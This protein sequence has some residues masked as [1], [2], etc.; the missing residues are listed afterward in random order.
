MRLFKYNFGEEELL[1]LYII[2][3]S[4]E[5]KV[6]R[7]V[8]SEMHESIIRVEREAAASTTAYI[9]Q[10]IRCIQHSIF[11]WGFHLKEDAQ[12]KKKKKRILEDDSIYY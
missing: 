11:I 12:I 10:S 5:R 8:L 1:L 3:G 4:K 2:A 6:F 9:E 7:I